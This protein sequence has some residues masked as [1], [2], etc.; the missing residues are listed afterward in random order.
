MLNGSILAD[1]INII[2]IVRPDVNEITDKELNI[3]L[4]GTI[5]NFT[6][7]DLVYI[8]LEVMKKFNIMLTADDVQQ[9]KFNTIAGIV[10]VVYSKIN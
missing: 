10:D 2:K 6:E 8:A 9:Y 7:R 3:E 4:T 1:I 5:M